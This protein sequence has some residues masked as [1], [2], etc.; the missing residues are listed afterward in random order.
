MVMTPTGAEYTKNLSNAATNGMYFARAAGKVNKVTIDSK[1]YVN[2][3]Q[4]A[5]IFKLAETDTIK[6]NFLRKSSGSSTCAN[7]DI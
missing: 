1:D 5:F 6:F 7:F 4:V 3:S 2:P